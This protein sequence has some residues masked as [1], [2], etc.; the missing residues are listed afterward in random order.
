MGMTNQDAKEIIA[1]LYR[2][3]EDVDEQEKKVDVILPGQMVIE[4]ACACYILGQN[5]DLHEEIRNLEGGD[6]ISSP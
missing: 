5:H 1:K 4:L 3:A 6:D 2:I